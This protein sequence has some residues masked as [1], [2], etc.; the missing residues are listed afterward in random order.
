MMDESVDFN[1]P[2]ICKFYIFPVLGS[3]N[4]TLWHLSGN[5]GNQWSQGQAPIP[6]QSTS[7]TIIF[8]GI[9]GKSYTGDIAIDDITFSSSTCGGL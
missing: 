4:R 3:Y 8:E 6:V 9:R 1:V 2:V 7:Y 5:Q